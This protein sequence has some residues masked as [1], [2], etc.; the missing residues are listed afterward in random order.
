MFNVKKYELRKKKGNDNKNEKGEKPQKFLIEKIEDKGKNDILEIRDDN[1]KGLSE[2]YTIELFDEIE[3]NLN[4]ENDITT[5]MDGRKHNYPH[6]ENN[7]S[8]YI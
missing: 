8:K 1:E 3:N 5:F 7:L 6:S 2:N 4:N